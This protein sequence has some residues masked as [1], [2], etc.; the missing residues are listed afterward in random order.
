[1][2]ALNNHVG[3]DYLEE[4]FIVNI[5]LLFFWLVNF[6]SMTHNFSDYCLVVDSLCVKSETFGRIWEIIA[7]LENRSWISTVLDRVRTTLDW[8]RFYSVDE[9][10]DFVHNS[11]SYYGSNVTGLWEHHLQFP[12]PMV[13]FL[14]MGSLFKNCLGGFLLRRLRVCLL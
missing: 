14:S 5:P 2:I 3:L 11:G 9:S 13:L 7:W 8:G 12:F 10:R 4:F 6:D 1:M